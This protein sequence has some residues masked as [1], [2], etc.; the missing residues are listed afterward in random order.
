MLNS[1]SLAL[2]DLKVLDIGCGSG[3]FLRYFASLGGNP[4]NLFG[5][6]L[7]PERLMRR[8]TNRAR[9]DPLFFM[10]RAIPAFSGQFF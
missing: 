6:D 7:I 3:Y 1:L 2:E 5:I 10:R 9:C 8:P 4:A